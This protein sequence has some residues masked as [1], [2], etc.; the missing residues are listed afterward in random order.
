[1]ASLIT[2][3][4]K[5][6]NT[7]SNYL[8]KISSEVRKIV[9][10]KNKGTLFIVKILL[11]KN[12][13]GAYIFFHAVALVVGVISGRVGVFVRAQ[14]ILGRNESESSNAGVFSFLKKDD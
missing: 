8:E 3:C 14:C 12:D 4:L 13:N 9:P 2:K 7:S 5:G 1:M 11:Y 10:F 6:K